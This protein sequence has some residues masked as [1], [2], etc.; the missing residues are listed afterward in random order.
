MRFFN[1]LFLLVVLYFHGIGNT[2]KVIRLL[3]IARVHLTMQLSIFLLC[4]VYTMFSK[5]YRYLNIL[6]ESYIETYCVMYVS[7]NTVNQC[8][9]T[10]TF[11][12]VT[13]INSHNDT[14]FKNIISVTSHVDT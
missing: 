1:H 11:Q 6:K 7:N 12:I 10:M 8:K 4:N 13:R 5:I 9:V 3:I 2:F 14:I